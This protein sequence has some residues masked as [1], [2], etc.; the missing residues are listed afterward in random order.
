[1]HVL[2]VIITTE[3]ICTCIA[4]YN[5]DWNHIVT[6][7]ASYN[8]DWNH[9]VT[10]IASYN[11]DWNYIHVLQVIITTETLYMYYKF[12]HKVCLSEF[13]VKYTFR[14]HPMKMSAKREIKN[15]VLFTEK[16]S[17]RLSNS[18]IL[19]CRRETNATRL[20]QGV[21]VLRKAWGLRKLVLVSCQPIDRSY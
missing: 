16:S 13:I 4:S 12:M 19:L 10:C 3:T 11:D 14:K 5:D 1:M 20:K 8:D 21:R 18:I 7:I 9:I 15:D 17:T 2:Q 6:C